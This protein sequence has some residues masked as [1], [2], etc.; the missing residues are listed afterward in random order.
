MKSTDS[1]DNATAPMTQ[2]FPEPPEFE[3]RE[4]RADEDA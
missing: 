1:M 2:H 4:R 3:N